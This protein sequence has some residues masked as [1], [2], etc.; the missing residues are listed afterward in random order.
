MGWPATV[1]SFFEVD[2]DHCVPA[3]SATLSMR[4]ALTDT[5]KQ[6][7]ACRPTIVTITRRGYVPRK[8]GWRWRIWFHNG[9]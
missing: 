4:D 2:C 7:G 3:L 1:R 9:D 6:H 8:K 5:V